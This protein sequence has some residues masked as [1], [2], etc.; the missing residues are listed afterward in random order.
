MSMISPGTLLES[1]T[2]LVPGLP[3]I[4]AS[5]G[6][7]VVTAWTSAVLKAAAMSASEVLT[8]CTSFSERSARSR[9]RASR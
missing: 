1:N 6:F 2:R 7:Q 5:M 4:S 8:T 9:A 3:L